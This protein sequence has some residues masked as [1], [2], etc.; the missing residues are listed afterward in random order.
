MKH[1]SFV[2]VNLLNCINIDLDKETFQLK[3]CS[4]LNSI[5]FQMQSI[6]FPLPQLSLISSPFNIFI[7]SPNFPIL[8]QTRKNSRPQ[9]KERSISQ[10]AASRGIHIVRVVSITTELTLP[11]SLKF[12]R[13]RGESFGARLRKTRGA[14]E[15][16]VRVLYYIT[17]LAFI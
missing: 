12:H 10:S 7:M 1:T 15:A 17:L 6:V 16:I 13:S 2:L 4:L 8:S 3:L 5:S 14:E 11:K 9:G